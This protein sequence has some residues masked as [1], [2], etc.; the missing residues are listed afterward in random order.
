MTH[1]SPIRIYINKTENRITF[2]IKIRRLS[3]VFNTWNDE[4][5]WKCYLEISEVILVHYNLVTIVK[6]LFE[7]EHLGNYQKFHQRILYF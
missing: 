7:V 3:P 5:L 6:N 1:N 4:T 2:K